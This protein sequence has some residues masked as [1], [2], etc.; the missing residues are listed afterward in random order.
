MDVRTKQLMKGRKRDLGRHFG[1][2]KGSSLGG[3][4]FNACK[5]ILQ[6]LR[7][8]FSNA[9]L[10]STFKYCINYTITKESGAGRPLPSFEAH[11]LYTS[12][13]EK[14]GTQP[15]ANLHAADQGWGC[16]IHHVGISDTAS[17]NPA[18]GTPPLGKHPMKHSWIWVTQDPTCRGGHA[19]SML[20]SPPTAIS[21]YLNLQPLL[22][23]CSLLLHLQ[24]RS[25]SNPR[26]SAGSST[27]QRLQV[28][29]CP[30]STPSPGDS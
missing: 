3:R 10:Q 15:A 7:R 16:C 19:Y 21:S 1:A 12:L 2:G 29:P 23:P 5:V 30:R 20:L 14:S 26:D 27:R 4:G 25:K 11:P 6:A 24:C 22:L 18:P 28:F 13:E 17:P 9:G 8:G